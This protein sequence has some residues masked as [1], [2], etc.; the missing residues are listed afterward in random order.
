VSFLNDTLI[1]SNTWEEHKCAVAE[2]LQ[3]IKDAGLTLNLNKSVFAIAELDYL[4]H[5]IGRGKIQPLEKKISALVQ[6]DR[7][8]NRK[9]LHSILGLAGYY[10]RYLPNFS[11]T[12]AV[13]SNLL[14]KHVKF[15]W[16]EDAQKAFPDFKSRLGSRPILRQADYIKEFCM[17]TGSTEEIDSTLS[18]TV[19]EFLRLTSR[20]KQLNAHDA[21]FLL[22]NCFSLLKLQYVLGCA[23][24]FN[25]QILQRYDNMKFQFS[26]GTIMLR[27]WNTP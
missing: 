5:R 8:K 7:P 27:C 6:Y 9:Q 3:R 1:F 15:E 20:L 17:P 18:R 19:A 11:H 23:P 26:A 14:Q 10:R 12:T 21:F 25:S 16:S 13:L 4:G 22:K 2:V 24:C